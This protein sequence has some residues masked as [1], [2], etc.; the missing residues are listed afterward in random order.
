[1]P[2]DVT[3]AGSPDGGVPQHSLG[4]H[5]LDPSLR[6]Q[7]PLPASLLDEYE[8]LR[9]RFLNR[10]NGR[11]VPDSIHARTFFQ[12]N[13]LRLAV[14]Q[15]EDSPFAPPTSFAHALW[16]ELNA[17]NTLPLRLRGGI[18]RGRWEVDT[19]Q[20]WLRGQ[21]NSPEEE[22]LPA[23]LNSAIMIAERLFDERNRQGEPLAEA[24]ALWS[25]TAECFRRVFGSLAPPPDTAYTPPKGH[26]PVLGPSF[27]SVPHAE[28]PIP[29]K[30]LADEAVRALAA[31]DSPRLVIFKG[32]PHSGQKRLL[33]FL[34]QRLP[35]AHLQLS[36]GSRLPV[37]ALALSDHTSAELID[38]VYC[39]YSAPVLGSA[40]NAAFCQSSQTYPL[41]PRCPALKPSWIA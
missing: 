29:L 13:I 30:A 14:K 9:R 37:L 6:S 33:R 28:D 27:K 17:A 35:N 22:T 34:L 7:P 2:N 32:P 12:V 11:P 15:I 10:R 36:D 18:R 21:A 8:G 16:A 26:A 19:L 38:E 23:I 3:S 39:F 41:T 24:I 40:N 25:D 31:A 4:L 1:V 5:H 20:T